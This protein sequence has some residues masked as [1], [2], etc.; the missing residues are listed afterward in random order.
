M[1]LDAATI[2]L[3]STI[4]SSIGGVASG[5]SSLRGAGQARDEARLRESAA[6]VDAAF[7]RKQAAVRARQSRR[8]GERLASK[9]IAL[10][11]KGGVVAHAGSPLLVIEET[12][13]EAE[14]DAMLA[15]ESGEQ[16][17]QATEFRGRLAAAESRARARS[18]GLEAATS[19]ISAGEP[20]LKETAR[21]KK[22]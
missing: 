7:A 16:E 9:Q 10:F 17:A 12:L 1:G 21:R 15:L 13:R 8:E 20:I 19:F 18:K 14:L 22:R 11:G 2:G 6:A 4:V 3:L 5:V